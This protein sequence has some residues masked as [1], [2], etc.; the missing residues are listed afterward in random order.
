MSLS[1]FTLSAFFSL[2]PRRCVAWTPRGYRR[3][4]VSRAPAPWFTGGRP[5]SARS[6]PRGSGHGC[7]YPPCT[8]RFTKAPR[9][10][11]QNVRW[12]CGG[13]FPHP[14]SR[15]RPY[16]LH[17]GA[18]TVRAA[19]LAIARRCPRRRSLLHDGMEA[20]PSAV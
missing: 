19:E 9:L 5:G 20:G 8:P 4:Q 17:A 14:R 6:S 3:R 1:L 10:P 18:H 13:W 15:L 7:R 2:L 16:G 11:L 12:N